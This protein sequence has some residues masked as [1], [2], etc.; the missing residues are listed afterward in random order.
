MH[1]PDFIYRFTKLEICTILPLLHLEA[2][3]WRNRYAPSLK[4]VICLLLIHQAY[5]DRLIRLRDLFGRSSAQLSSIYYD[6][7]IHLVQH[8]RG[9]L[10][11][12]LRINDYDRLK[13]FGRAVGVRSGLGGDRIWGFIDRTFRPFCCPSVRQQMHYSGYKRC[14]GF[15]YQAIATPNGLI[16]SLQ[17]P[18]LGLANDWTIF[19]SSDLQPKLQ[20][21]GLLPLSEHL[22]TTLQ[23]YGDC[24]ALYLYGDPAYHNTY[25]I[26]ASYE[27]A[28]LCNR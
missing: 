12:H 5:P 10:Q 24:E 21:V 11:W 13:A 9:L 16:S 26:I 15:K 8:F 25:G 22:L 7:M 27:S 1:F 17:G 4:L 23:I 19:L 14:H 3:E 20:E 28:E 6:T 2:I 18:Y